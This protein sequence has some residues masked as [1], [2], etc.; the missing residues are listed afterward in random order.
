MI[1]RWATIGLILAGLLRV[2][3]IDLIDVAGRTGGT[4]DAYAQTRQ[5]LRALGVRPQWILHTTVYLADAKYLAEVDRA[6]RSYFGREFPARTVLVAGLRT[7][8]AMLEISATASR[9][10]RRLIGN[11]FPASAAAEAGGTLF[12]SAVRGEGADVE[13]QTHRLMQLQNE[14]LGKAGYSFADLVLSKVYLAE[15]AGYSALNE[16]YRRYVTAPPP[17]RATI[18]ANPVRPGEFL[19]VQSVAV[20]GSGVGRPSGPGITSPIHSY[21]VMAAPRLYITGMTGRMADGRFAPDLADQTRQALAMISEQLERHT[22]GFRNVVE[23]TV[24]LRDIGDVAPV[25]S[26]LPVTGARTI[27]GIPPSSPE[28]LVEIQMV[29]EIL[30]T[31]PASAQRSSAPGR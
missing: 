13:Q 6:Y 31:R 16:A 30:A 25:M 19:Q 9:Q 15:P 20:R 18:H 22:L 3:A 28:S 10:P 27:V 5:A 7:P 8:G 14:V 4:G 24:W 29:A 21:S 12:L 2:E 17:A 23:T 11:A 1:S 26:L